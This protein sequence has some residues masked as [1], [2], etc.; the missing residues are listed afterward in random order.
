M[1]ILVWLDRKQGHLGQEGHWVR[2]YYLASDVTSREQVWLSSD[3]LEGV[4]QGF[5][6][7]LIRLNILFIDRV[8]RTFNQFR[9][10][11][12][13][14]MLLELDAVRVAP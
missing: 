9:F 7:G 13:G 1:Q 3:V 11:A 4:V 10:L 2:S 8:F 12:D 6:L 5:A 14:L